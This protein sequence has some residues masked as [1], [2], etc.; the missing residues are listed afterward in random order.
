METP[1]PERADPYQLIQEQP[2]FL[3]AIITALMNKSG[4]T[5]V[6]VNSADVQAAINSCLL[7]MIA[8]DPTQMDIYL[9][10]PPSEQHVG[11]DYAEPTIP[12]DKEGIQ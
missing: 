6:H 5:H 8:T 1:K 9:V 4:V 12:P 2:E 11:L 10:S 7:R 3:L